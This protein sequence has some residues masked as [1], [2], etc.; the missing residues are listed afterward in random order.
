MLVVYGFALNFDV[1]HV[2]LAVQDLDQ[3]EASRSLIA[4]FVNSTY[5]DITATPGAGEDLARLTEARVAKAVLVIP[6]GFGTDLGA[7]R[8]AQVQLLLDGADSMTATTILGYAGA[9]SAEYNIRLLG[10][11]VRRAGRRLE[12][13]ITYAPRILFNPELKSTRFLVPGLIGLLMMLTGMLS[14]A[15]SVVREKE[16]GT[17]EQVRMAP[18]HTS[19]LIL[20]KTLPYLVISLLA[21]VIILVTARALFAVEVRGSYVALLVVI[22]IYLVGALGFGLLIST[23]AHTQALAFQIGL[24]TSLLPAMLLS[25]FIFQI[26]VMP[27]WL[28]AITYVVP[29]RYFLVVLR[30]IILKGTGLGP[31]W[32]QVGFLVAFA[33]LMLTLASVRLG[34]QEDPGR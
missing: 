7:G 32:D 2:S 17:M 26:R 24:L 11:A 34:R 19:Q 12:P 9:L 28:Q 27:I 30:G 5:F 20:G 23:I 3:S 13:A 18:I 8:E 31:Y 29:A 1:R 21:T 14:T 10:R 6:A 4:A 16:R 25:G 22:L 15:M 33:L